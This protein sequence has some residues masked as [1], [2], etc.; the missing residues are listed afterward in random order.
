[1]LLF[2][3]DA[4]GPMPSLRVTPPTPDRPASPPLRL[5]A[6]DSSP[7]PTGLRRHSRPSGPSSPLQTDHRTGPNNHTLRLEDLSVGS[8]L[9]ASMH[10]GGRPRPAPHSMPSLMMSPIPM[11]ASAVFDGGL[12]TARKATAGYP[13]SPEPDVVGPQTRFT[14]MSAGR[15][16]Q[17]GGIDSPG[18][19]LEDDVAPRCL[20]DL[21]DNLTVGDGGGSQEA[22]A[23]AGVD[24]VAPPPDQ[25]G[26]VTPS[27]PSPVPSAQRNGLTHRAANIATSPFAWS[28]ATSTS[29]DSIITDPGADEPSDLAKENRP[30]PG[31]SQVREPEIG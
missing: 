15:R 29:R 4:T 27:P 24:M 5:S 23:A 1:M 12:S 14:P 22:A 21:F 6:F 19:R 7:T 17:L 16:I 8:P 3:P 2:S 26:C 10:T 20:V 25:H 28:T 13:F 30:P 18:E 31:A 11:H 9:L